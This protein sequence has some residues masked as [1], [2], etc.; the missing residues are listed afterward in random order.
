M[1]KVI[2]DEVR[3]I[4]SEPA[5]GITREAILQLLELSS[6]E[7]VGDAEIR[8]MRA[9]HACVFE[10]LRFLFLSLKT[11]P[12]VPRV[13]LGNLQAEMSLH[14][15]LAN[16]FTEVCSYRRC[17][18]KAEGKI[19]QHAIRPV[20][21][22]EF[23]PEHA[24]SY[25]RASRII[26]GWLNQFINEI[27]KY[28]A[29]M[30]SP[31]NYNQI[32]LAPDRLQSLERTDEWKSLWTYE[33]LDQ[34]PSDSRWLPLRAAHERLI[35]D[36]AYRDVAQLDILPSSDNRVRQR[37]SEFS[38]FIQHHQRKLE[39]L[40]KL[41]IDDGTL[42]HV[43]STEGQRPKFPVLDNSLDAVKN[44][45]PATV[46][47]HQQPVEASPPPK[48]PYMGV[49][50]PWDETY[51]LGRE[52]R[53]DAETSSSKPPKGPQGGDTL[54]TSI[55]FP[56][57]VHEPV[58]TIPNRL[59]LLDL[60]GTDSCREENTGLPSPEMIN[61]RGAA[62]ERAAA[63]LDSSLG[64][65]ERLEEQPT[66]ARSSAVRDRSDTYNDRARGKRPMDAH[67]STNVASLSFDAW[68]APRTYGSTHEG[69]S[70]GSRKLRNS[71]E[72]RGE[73]RDQL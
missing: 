58:Q 22:Y 55:A 46:R 13:I 40:E 32:L 52:A 48:V 33:E 24:K 19:N 67:E 11:S 71:G 49:Y 70:Q 8:L 66:P 44:L 36:R 27:T 50:T 42:G 2:S 17:M 30:Q 18:T 62:E 63:A 47:P 6:G 3:Q 23:Y 4:V 29:S 61:F 68:L 10:Q 72:G 9:Y 7:P 53:D 35:I 38:K 65:S 51:V 5:P 12:G 34:M 14:F 57:I 16:E 28:Q 60:L 39:K 41:L 15:R 45:A 21:L 1:Q 37:L 26:D 20:D 64:R 25:M 54:S 43:V 69:S 31:P 56:D 59:V 73:R